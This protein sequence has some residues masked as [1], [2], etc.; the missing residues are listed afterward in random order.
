[1]NKMLFIATLAVALTALSACTKEMTKTDTAAKAEAPAATAPA[2]T[3]SDQEAYEAALAAAKTEIKKAAKKLKK[4]PPK[5]TTELL[6]RW[7]KKP[8]SRLSRAR[9]RQHH[10]STWAILAIC[11]DRL[12][13]SRP[14]PNQDSS[15]LDSAFS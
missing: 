4:L 13:H 15:P 2:P 9:N 10:R 3:G 11:T 5:A 8:G 6:P 7:R 14:E 1:M 12:T